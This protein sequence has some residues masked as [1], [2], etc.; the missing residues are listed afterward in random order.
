M[1]ETFFFDVGY[2]SNE[3]WAE[4]SRPS[5]SFKE[6]F[7]RGKSKVK[8]QHC[9]KSRGK[10]YAPKD[11]VADFENKGGK[12]HDI[13]GSN[14]LIPLY[15]ERV[16]D[17][18]VSE[19]VSGF[20]AYPVEIREVKNQTLSRLGEKKY[21]ALDIKGK[22][23]VDLNHLEEQGV[24]VCRHC[25]SLKRKPGAKFGRKD[26]EFL[27]NSWDGSELM[28]IGNVRTGLLFCTTRVVE[29]ANK[30][31]LT[32]FSFGWTYP[33]IDFD[34]TQTDWKDTVAKK[35]AEKESLEQS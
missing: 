33:F 3:P 28:K 4:L 27:M 20:E 10:Y 32:N 26:Y 29:I 2:A 7:E 31:K 14:S 35:L 24:Q 12:W 22:I 9:G 15:S 5:L 11:F 13:I 34:Y 18:F 21:Y 30:Y 19:K 8:C 25:G 6:A 23:N 17:V 16:I 1:K